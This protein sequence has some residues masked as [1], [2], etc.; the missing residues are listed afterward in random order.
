MTT[1][2]CRI[3]RVT[4]RKV[5]RMSDYPHK[6]GWMGAGRMGTALIKRLLNAGVDVSVYNRTRSKAEHLAEL[7]AT[8]VDKPI[9]LADRDIIFSMVASGKDVM[10]VM[11]GP[12][13]VLSDPNQ[14]PSIIVDST[15]IDPPTSVKLRAEAA[16]LGV[17]MLAA[18]VSGNPKVVTSGQLTVVT[19][20][21]REAHDTVLPYLNLFGQK[22]TYVGAEEQA[23]LVKICHNVMLGVVSQT[24]AEITV[25]AEAGGVNRSAFLEFFNDS[26]M[27]SVFSRY[28]SPSI[29]N[30]D[31]TPT[32]TWPLLRKDLELGLE[33]A[34]DYNVPMPTTALVN[35]IVIEGIG[36]G[37]GEQDFMA[38]LTKTA[39][40]SGMKL[41]PENIEFDDGL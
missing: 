3:G 38:L 31:Y 10:E 41:E 20:G 32:F 15:T 34:H 18:P 22:V 14:R 24:L 19:S 30:L 36:L 33:A 25:L 23:R 29:V 9:E 6:V 2:D 13:G 21:P 37:Y 7:G 26:V 28:K 5:R 4:A 40:G 35:Q 27:G 8:I 16:A 1:I 17:Q 39:L 11:T 12:E